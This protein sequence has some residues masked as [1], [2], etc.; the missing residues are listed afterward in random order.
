MER[1]L[2]HRQTKEPVNGYAAPK[3]PRHPSTLQGQMIT[4]RR[5]AIVIGSTLFAMNS[6]YAPRALLS[7]HR[8]VSRALLFSPWFA[9]YDFKRPSPNSTSYQSAR[10]DIQLWAIW[11]TAIVA[12]TVAGVAGAPPGGPSHNPLQRPTG[13]KFADGKGHPQN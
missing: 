1:L 9:K 5:L 8:S 7:D 4:W 13:E 11:S 6:L 12:L 3:P 10:V 2:R